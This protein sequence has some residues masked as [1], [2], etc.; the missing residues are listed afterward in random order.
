MRME[1]QRCQ[2]ALAVRGRGLACA[3][4][5][6]TTRLQVACGKYVASEMARI[7][8]LQRN[9]GSGAVAARKAVRLAPCGAA[10]INGIAAT[11]GRGIGHV[12]PF[13]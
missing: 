4:R 7:N 12:P 10:C 11:G 9:T 5:L 13:A 8:Q 1:A 2:G 3:D 6:V